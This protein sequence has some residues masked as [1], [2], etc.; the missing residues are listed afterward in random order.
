MLDLSESIDDSLPGQIDT[1]P[2]NIQIARDFV[3][4]RWIDRANSRCDQTPVDL[5]SACKFA[6][7]FAWQLFGGTLAGNCRH[8]FVL[9][10]DG[11]VLDL[12]CGSA[13]LESMKDPYVH[14]AEFFGNDEHLSSLDSCLPRVS[15]WIRQF[16]DIGRF[17]EINESLNDYCAK[18]YIA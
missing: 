4:Q 14:D 5:S 8:Q 17:H 11:S 9:S 2:E 10:H 3:F 6:S 15:D 7:L 13:E 12:C 18:P 16:E 1:T